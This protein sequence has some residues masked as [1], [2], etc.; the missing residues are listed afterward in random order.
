MIKR[1]WNVIYG[2][3]GN[4]PLSRWFSEQ[5]ARDACDILNA[6]L[7]PPAHSA[8]ITVMYVVEPGY[9][10]EVSDDKGNV[11]HFD[12]TPVVVNS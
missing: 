7:P 12:M 9:V 10:F 4:L 5:Q 11:M 2:A 6:Q 3:S 8:W 1:C